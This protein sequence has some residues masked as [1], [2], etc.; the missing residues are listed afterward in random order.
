MYGYLES[1]LKERNFRDV[2]SLPKNFPSILIFYN[3]NKIGN[4]QKSCDLFNC[5]F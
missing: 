1:I 3:K 5:K 4:R 2:P